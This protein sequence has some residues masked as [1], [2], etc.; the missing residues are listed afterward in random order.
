MVFEETKQLDLKVSY[1]DMIDNLHEQMNFIEE[2]RFA[3]SQKPIK[4]NLE[5]SIVV[6]KKTKSSRV[7]IS[8]LKTK[9]K[10]SR[11]EFGLYHP[12][13]GIPVFY[14]S[15]D[16]DQEFEE[17]F[18]INISRVFCRR[19][20][21]IKAKLE[22]QPHKQKTD[23][24]DI[25][26]SGETINPDVKVRQRLGTRNENDEL[27]AISKSFAGD[28]S[29]PFKRIIVGGRSRSIDEIVEQRED[30]I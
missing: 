1:E 3:N 27:E 26:N 25:I 14:Q 18:R 4:Y 21:F 17:D 19:Q 28:T 24:Q 2:Y 12:N 30:G 11:P 15:P 20:D 7:G 9:K 13:S 23:E 5:D 29:N 6:E 16:F 8:N 10:S 22:S